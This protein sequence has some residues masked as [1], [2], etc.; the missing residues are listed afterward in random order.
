MLYISNM[1][2]IGMSSTRILNIHRECEVINFRKKKRVLCCSYNPKK[3]LI[4][5]NLKEIGNNSDLL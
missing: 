1:H 4:F 5:N 2:G 3:S